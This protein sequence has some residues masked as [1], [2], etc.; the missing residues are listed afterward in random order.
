MQTYSHSGTVPASGAI[1]TVLAGAATAAVA[2]VIYG[3]AFYWIPFVY[4]NF[5]FT[6]G[7]AGVIGAAIAVMALR[8]KVRNNFVVGIMAVLVTL[9]GMYVYWAAYAW[10]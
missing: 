8:G 3:Y 7:F 6:L 2:G 9:L 4:L 10:A 5:L 1:L